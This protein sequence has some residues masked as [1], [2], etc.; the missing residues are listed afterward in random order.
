MCCGILA[1]FCPFLGYFGINFGIVIGRLVVLS[2]CGIFLCILGPC[3]RFWDV[4]GPYAR[5]R[6]R[7]RKWMLACGPRPA[8]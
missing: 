8:S 7:P 2:P 3:K 4:G 1:Q 6:P 5:V